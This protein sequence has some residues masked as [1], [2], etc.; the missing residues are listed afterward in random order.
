MVKMPMTLVLLAAW[1]AASP[2]PVQDTPLEM[3]TYQMVL[4]KKGAVAPPSSPAE[5]KQMQDAHLANLADL[6]RKR[7]NLL[8]G[9]VTADA[10]LRGIVI[11]A[12]PNADAAKAAFAG[13]P[14]VNA[15]VMALDVR[16][17]MGPKNWFG[18]PASYDVTNPSTLEPLVL[19]FLV[20]VANAAQNQQA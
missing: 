1:L 8:Y 18:L 11:M 6:N 2:A 12:V 13:D 7:I 14:F 4:L 5:Q 17:W 9:P 19:G 3:T 15:G 10:D 20:R 16:P